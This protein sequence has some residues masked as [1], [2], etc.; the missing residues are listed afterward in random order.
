M[1]SG[2]I[3]ITE[4]P[5]LESLK[6]PPIVIGIVNNGGLDDQVLSPIESRPPLAWFI[7]FAISSAAMLVGFVSIGYTIATGIGVWGNNVPVALAARAGCVDGTG[8]A[9]RHQLALPRTGWRAD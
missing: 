7:A 8:E 2:S 5:S 6:Q 3:V 1:K 9:R 4:D